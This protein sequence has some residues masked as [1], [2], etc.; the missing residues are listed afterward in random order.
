MVIG[1]GTTEKTPTGAVLMG[2][3]AVQKGYE[4]L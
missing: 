2:T 4:K 1:T 3:E